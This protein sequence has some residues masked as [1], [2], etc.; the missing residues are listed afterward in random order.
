MHQPS[1]KASDAKRRFSAQ[2]EVGSA[3]RSLR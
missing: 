1:S 3:S 2:V